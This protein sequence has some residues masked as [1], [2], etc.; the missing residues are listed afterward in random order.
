MA[1]WKCAAEI[2][3]ERGSTF[4]F[5]I[6]ILTEAGAQTTEGKTLLVTYEATGSADEA[7]ALMAEVHRRCYV[8]IEWGAVSPEE[9][10]WAS[11][12]E[13][14]GGSDE[15]GENPADV[16]VRAGDHL[17]GDDFADGAGGLGASINRRLHGGDITGDDGCDQGVADLLH[18]ANEGDVGGLEH[19][20]GA[21][22]ESGE[23]AGFEK[24][25][26]L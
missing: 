5:P 24:T 15:L 14:G 1:Q 10:A 22:N 13:G 16:T 11:W 8:L 2:W 3:T 26:G 17:H 6:S 7:A 9:F 25:K 20:V 19:G 12:G 23:T 21:G 4:E 18:R